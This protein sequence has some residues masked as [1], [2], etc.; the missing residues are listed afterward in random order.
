VDDPARY[1]VL[2]DGEPSDIPADLIPSLPPPP[3]VTLDT[4][5][6]HFSGVRTEAAPL[7]L[8]D[9]LT[10][11]REDIGPGKFAAAVAAHPWV[12]EFMR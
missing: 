10:L 1:C 2:R 7:Q 4:V 9:V 11:I 5:L 3:R 8:L 6:S 12:R